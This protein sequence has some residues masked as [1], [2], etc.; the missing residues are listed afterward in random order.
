MSI[1]RNDSLAHG[2][3]QTKRVSSAQLAATKFVVK[4]KLC[5]M[6]QTKAGQLTL[7]FV[8]V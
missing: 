6:S 3:G 4:Q 8:T 5:Q 2:F 7:N 1:D